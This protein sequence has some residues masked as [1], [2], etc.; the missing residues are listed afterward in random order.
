MDKRRDRLHVLV[1]ELFQLLNTTEESDS[2]RRFNPTTINSCRTAHVMRL[3]EILPEI[4][5]ILDKDQHKKK[6]NRK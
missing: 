2:G 3:N 5:T 1:G 4:Q 6:G